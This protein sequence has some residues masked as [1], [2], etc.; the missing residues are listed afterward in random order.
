MTDGPGD[1]VKDRF[2]SRFENE[3]EGSESQTEQMDKSSRNA[4]KAGNKG[5]AQTAKNIKK[6][7]NTFTFYLDDELGGRLNR[8]YKKL[9]W[10]LADEHD[11]SLSKTRHYYPLVVQ[12]GVER[13]DS[14]D[15]SEVKERLEELEG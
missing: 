7:W 15:R 14:L 2:A 10:Q 6:E 4:K 12:L 3:D 8:L 5:K 1:D 11:V 13:L 9:D